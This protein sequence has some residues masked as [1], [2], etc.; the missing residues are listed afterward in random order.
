MDYKPPFKTDNYQEQTI[1]I[2]KTYFRD[3]KQVESQDSFENWVN[4]FFEVNNSDERYLP[5]YLGEKLS[6][7]SIDWSTVFHCNLLSFQQPFWIDKS[8]FL[9]RNQL[10][11]M[12]KRP[13]SKPLY[14]RDSI[15]LDGWDYS[16]IGSKRKHCRKIFRIIII[17]HF[18]GHVVYNDFISIE[19]GKNVLR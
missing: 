13:F 10:G 11:F 18:P 6:H 1:E 5:G 15:R 12:A 14:V 2:K 7:P 17:D 3:L 9:Q 4:F 8:A 19:K 16:Y